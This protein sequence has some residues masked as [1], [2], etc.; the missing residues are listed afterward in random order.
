MKTLKAFKNIPQ[1]SVYKILDILTHNGLVW[2]ILEKYQ[3]ARSI[4]LRELLKAVMLCGDVKNG[5][6]VH[7]CK[8]CGSEHKVGFSCGKR[9][10]NKCGYRR[11]ENWVKKAKS[12]VLNVGHRHIIFT[13]PEVLWDIF[14]YERDLLKLLSQVSQEVI[15]LWGLEKGIIK[16]GIICI[17]HTFGY[18]LKWNVH[19]HLI[20][21]EGGLTSG[22]SWRDWPWNRKKYKQPYISFSFLQSK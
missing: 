5:Y 22:N 7:K 11:T 13:I 10:C 9:F 1:K 20:V 18:D 12:K 4:Y 19:L 15:R 2:K 14:A 3:S 17:I 6:A 8:D 16:H 21:T